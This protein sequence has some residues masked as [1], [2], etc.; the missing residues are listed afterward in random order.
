MIA[1]DTN[2]LV[3]AHREDSDSHEIAYR[4][5]AELA[6]DRETWAIRG[7]ACTSSSPSLWSADGDFG[8]FPD[9]VVVNPLVKPS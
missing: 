8:R 1:V 6:E 5:L 2:I 3:Y 4:R 9:L 7:P